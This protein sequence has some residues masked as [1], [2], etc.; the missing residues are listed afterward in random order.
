MKFEKKLMAISCD[1]QTFLH[2]VNNTLS[3]YRKGQDYHNYLDIMRQ[4]RQYGL[5]YLL[6]KESFFRLLYQTL[7]K[8]NMNSRGAKLVPFS[9]FVKT[10]QDSKEEIMQLAGFSLEQINDSELR[11]VLQRIRSLFDRVTIMK[12]RL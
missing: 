5:G 4:R 9:D 11:I 8:W 12:S 7:I 3:T 10:I 2:Y 1:K 6:G